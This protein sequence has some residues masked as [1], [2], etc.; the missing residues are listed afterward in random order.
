MFFVSKGNLFDVYLAFHANCLLRRQFAW[1]AKVYFH[2]KKK[3]EKD[4]QNVT[5]RKQAYSN[6]LKILPPK[7][8]NFQIK[9]SNIFS[10]F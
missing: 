8:E 4:F 10:Y 1:N 9:K 3:Y 6:I 7:T 5:L 2:R